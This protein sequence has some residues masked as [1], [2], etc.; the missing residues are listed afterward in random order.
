MKKIILLLISFFTIQTLIAQ[1]YNINNFGAKGDGKNDTKAIQKAIDECS[2]NGGTVIF[3]TGTFA[4]GTIY[5]KSNVTIHLSKGAVWT[6]IP[7][8]DLFPFQKI[9]VPGRMDVV[10]RKA[11][12]YAA[13]QKNISIT[14]EGTIS[15]RGDHKIWQTHKGNDPERPFGIRI[16]K[17]KN[18]KFKDIKLINS[19]FWM[20][21]I[22]CS[23][24]IKIDGVDIFNHCNLNNDGIDIDGCHN[25]VISN[26]IIDSED[27]A[28]VFKSEGYRGCEDIVVNNCI[29]SS[30]A[31]PFKMGTGSV[32]GF[33]RISATNCV[34]RPSKSKENHH[35]LQA[36][37]GLAG[38][39]LGN[40]DGGTMED[41][42]ISNFVIDSVETPIFIR[43]GARHDRFWEGVPKATGGISKNIKISNIVATS[44]DEI[45]CAI[46][47]YPGHRVEN[48]TFQNIQIHFLGKGT[49]KDTS[50][51]V[52]EVI[53]G[54]PFNRMFGGVLPAYGFYV[55]HAENVHFDQ[56]R[57]FLLNSDERPAF[58]FDDV[59]DASLTNFYAEHSSKSQPLIQIV[60]SSGITIEGDSKLKNIEDFIHVQGET[61][62][63]IR[64]KDNLMLKESDAF[65]PVNFNAEPVNETISEI[66]LSWNSSNNKNVG[67]NQFVIYRNSKEIKRTRKTTF[68]DKNIEENEKYTY[69]IATLN[70]YGMLSEKKTAAVTSLTDKKA[71]VLTSHYLVD[72]RTIE[73]YFSEP[74]NKKSALNIS[75][76][77]FNNDISIQGIK[78]NEKQ[79]KLILTTTPLTRKQKLS[80]NNITDDTEKGN[81]IKTTSIWVEDNPLVGYWISEKEGEITSDK[82]DNNNTGKINNAQWVNGKVN[83][84]LSF[85]GKDHYINCGNAPSINISGDMAISVWFK[86]D[87]PSAGKYYRILSKR[88]IWNSPTGYELEINPSQNRINI[89]GGAKDGAQQGV[90]QYQ[91]D[92]KWHH[93]V[94]MI[95][96]EAAYVYIDGK[97]A[98]KDDNV[99]EPAANDVPLFIGATPG[100]TNNFEGVLDELKIFNRALSEQEINK[101]AQP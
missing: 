46:T 74:L 30:F 92:N 36:W 42:T 88:K 39:D 5:L 55:R 86:V 64:L 15:P 60:N 35:E 52:P 89:S 10:K 72:N 100:N 23:D 66:R 47:G 70:G 73:L 14:G 2:K 80:I 16:V 54:Y 45:S 56:I 20:I 38:I 50:L 6:A 58:V 81:K 48:I 12:I 71:P 99:A 43:L 4:T 26:C 93:M 59:H 8:Q 41:I 25:V 57:L 94:A 9:I 65:A 62:S 37:G 3:P 1:T 49:A 29:L 87:N 101:L 13:N 19:A 34:I 75:N 40:V 22:Y 44:S 83:Q 27:D 63:S 21:H 17:C 97:P 82:S 78:M 7:D 67:L 28:L 69:Q 95:K 33:R 79:D 11:F 76:Y 32:Y 98:G 85:A 51:K 31:S 18:V 53:G 84:A 96:N 91:F 61:S 90:I 68:T 24:F 77:E